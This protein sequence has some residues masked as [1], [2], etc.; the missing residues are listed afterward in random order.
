M[1]I[2]TACFVYCFILFNG[3]F[4]ASGK[5]WAG[6]KKVPLPPRL[7]V[8]TFDDA[9]RS[10][11]EVAAPVLRKHG[12]GATF[13]VTAAW[14]EDHAHFLNWEEIARLHEMGFEVGNHSMH[15]VALHDPQPLDLLD[16][17][18][19]EVEA[20]LAKVGVPRP[21]SFSWPGN[22]F[23]PEAVKRLRELG[24]LFGRRGTLPD[25]PE[26]LPVVGMGPIYEIGC[27]DPLLIPSGGLSVPDWTLEDFQKVV[28]PAR[29]H[30]RIVV[31]QFHGT[32]D[33]AHPF[34]STPAAEFTR[35]VEYL[36]LENFTVIAMRDLARYM[37]PE[38]CPEDPMGQTLFAPQP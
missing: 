34:C 2:S 31:L 33:G 19:Q 11:L 17:E 13:F 1:R 22:H 3:L 24:Y 28:E 21:V 10:H 5:A 15:H 35:F 38:P 8:M 36:A 32:P 9:V 7:V 6:E 4:F 23:G 14:M 37:E 30:G 27:H 16:R 20:E 12:F 26:N 18:I 25:I 29:E